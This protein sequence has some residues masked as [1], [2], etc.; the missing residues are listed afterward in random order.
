MSPEPMPFTDYQAAFAARIRDP[1]QAA[2]PPGAAA[3]RMRVY[4]EL[5]FNNLEGFLLSAYPVTRKLL[6]ARL[7]RRTVRR[8]FVE[9]RSHSP[10]FRDIP[11]AFLD[12]MRASGA[13]SLPALPFLP[14]FM[15]YEWLELAVSISS[16]EVDPSAIDTQ[17]DLMLGRPALHPTA[18]LACYAYPVHQIGPRFKPA[19][20]DGQAWCYLL[21]RDEALCDEEAAGQDE[22]R[23]ILLNPLSAGLLELLRERRL[24]GREALAHLAEQLTTQAAPTLNPNFMQLGDELLR[25]LRAQGAL[26]GT[27]RNQ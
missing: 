22:V 10:L 27:W 24:S 26:L 6:G 11:K 19:A 23:F 9:H 16:E 21:F 3:K 8:F 15:H 25:D 13:A 4:E 5:L 20:A 17:G 1:K 2:R 7:W 12:W 18:R 14:E